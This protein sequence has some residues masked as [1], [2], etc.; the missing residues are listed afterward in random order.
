MS[1]MQAMAS[2]MHRARLRAHH[3]SDASCRRAHM[4]PSRAT[5]GHKMHAAEMHTLHTQR[6][7]SSPP[8]RCHRNADC[9]SL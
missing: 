3:P 4:G 1:S 8:L 5:H 6:G 9:M 2:G 7:V